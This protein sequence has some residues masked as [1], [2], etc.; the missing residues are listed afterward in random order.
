MQF[1]FRCPAQF[2]SSKTPA[3]THLV[4]AMSGRSASLLASV[5]TKLST[6]EAASSVLHHGLTPS[7]EK[8]TKT[9]ITG[10]STQLFNRD[11]SSSPGHLENTLGI[12]GETQ[13]DLLFIESQ[14]V[15]LGKPLQSYSSNSGSVLSPYS[16]QPSV[17]IMCPCWKRTN[18][19]LVL[20]RRSRGYRAWC[21]TAMY[22]FWNLGRLC[23]IHVIPRRRKFKSACTF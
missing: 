8:G 19:V 13:G 23:L 18:N 12:L 21:I 11:S 10:F 6:I 2:P 16:Y 4:T 7:G 3:S 20:I 15:R 5:D 9:L 1:Q 17:H 14:S 22:Y